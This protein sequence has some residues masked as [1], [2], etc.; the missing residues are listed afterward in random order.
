MLIQAYI[1]LLSYSPQDRNIASGESTNHTM[2]TYVSVCS[3]TVMLHLCLTFTIILTKYY[4]LIKQEFNRSLLENL[5]QRP[6]HIDPTIVSEVNMARLMFE[7]F[8]AHI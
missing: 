1:S 7:I 8:H 5:K 2:K 4:V 6:S 3:Y